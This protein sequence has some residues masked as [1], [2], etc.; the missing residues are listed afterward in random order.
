MAMPTFCPLCYWYRL[1]CGTP[2]FSSFP[3]IF[4]DIDLYTKRLVRTHIDKH[5]HPSKW[6]GALSVADGH[7]DPGTLQ[8]HDKKNDIIL[9]GI[10]DELL[11]AEDR[12]RWFL[13]DYKT[14]RYTAGQDRLLPLYKVRLLAYAFLLVKA[15][16]QNHE[17]SA[18]IYFARKAVTARNEKLTAPR[19]ARS[20]ARPVIRAGTL[21]LPPV[22]T[23]LAAISVKPVLTQFPET[24][25]T[26]PT[27]FTRRSIRLDLHRKPQEPTPKV[28]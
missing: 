12:S 26:S 18:L 7:A 10:L 11:H 20:P 21:S 8:W 4:N 14:A 25:P 22:P 6:M 27:D 3:C 1:H 15:G 19:G 23:W 24:S 5:A 2:P 28:L 9:R 13:V 17:I 16:Y